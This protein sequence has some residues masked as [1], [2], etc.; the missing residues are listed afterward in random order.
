[1]IQSRW[2]WAAVV[3][4][5]L[6]APAQGAGLSRG[7][8]DIQSAGPLA[9]GPGGLLFIGDTRGAAI[10]AVETGDQA[11]GSP[12]ASI[13]VEG[14]SAKIAELLGTE[15]REILINDL[16][17]NPAS[18]KAYL[19]AS[20]GRG[21]D[22]SPVIVRVDGTGKIDVLEMKDVAFGKAALA[23]PPAANA[24]AKRGVSPRNESI[25]DL[26][27]VD[28]QV[29]VA[30]LSN[31]EFSSRLVAIPYPFTGKAGE[32]TSVE[33]YHGAHGQFETKSPVRTFAPYKID[34]E[35][36]LMAAY[37]CTPLVKVPVA[38]LKPGQHFK[39]TT[40]AEL[41]N[42]NRPLD[43]I[44][45]RKDGK[46]FL[47]MANNSRG[48]MKIPADGLD[49]AAS[50][51]ERVKDGKTEGQPYQA[52]DGLKG[53]TQLDSLDKDFALVVVEREGGAQD[54]ETIPL[55]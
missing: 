55:P 47:L 11:P 24:P 18:G 17:V 27:Y 31:E 45:Y 53:V 44:V 13:K 22:A 35:P 26:A 23:N 48:V 34:G 20:R 7:T 21:P 5:A 4:L 33:I 9:F 12:G 50:I 36:Y 42:R 51:T 29:F 2:K 16:A 39:G 49:K 52:V 30:G 8:P 32:G 37:T 14:L 40:V 43:M 25:T 15:P 54:L 1:M 46:D 10:F 41:G 3:G 6:A 28:G 38:A 19:S